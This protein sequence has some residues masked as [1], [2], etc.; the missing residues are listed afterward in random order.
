VAIDTLNALAEHLNT[1]SVEGCARF[2]EENKDHLCNLIKRAYDFATLSGDFYML[3]PARSTPPLNLP[4]EKIAFIYK[5]TKEHLIKLIQNYND[6][7]D[8]LLPL[9]NED[10]ADFYETMQDSL[11]L[12][13]RDSSH[14]FQ[15]IIELPDS[16]KPLFYE[17]VA[18]K[19]PQFD[20]IHTSMDIDIVLSPFPRSTLPSETQCRKICQALK[21]SG[22]LNAILQDEKSIEYLFSSNF[23]PK[24]L[25]IVIDVFK[26]RLIEIAQQNKDEF[27]KLTQSLRFSKRVI[28]YLAMGARF[29]ELALPPNEFNFNDLATY[30]NA[31]TTQ[32]LTRFLYSKFF[33]PLDAENKSNIF[34]SIKDQLIQKIT[35]PQD[36]LI[37]FLCLPEAPCKEICQALDAE[38][39]QTLIPNGQRLITFLNSAEEDKIKIILGKLQETKQLQKIASN[40]NFLMDLL[41]SLPLEKF[42]IAFNI[43]KEATILDTLNKKK[44][45]EL[46]AIHLVD[47]D[48]SDFIYASLKEDFPRIIN[49]LHK[50]SQI[51]LH[52]TEE[53]RTKTYEIMKKHSPQFTFIDSIDYFNRIHL[54]RVLSDLSLE[55]GRALLA[56]LDHNQRLKNLINP[57]ED[58]LEGFFR[59]LSE[60]IDRKSSSRDEK[61][62]LLINQIEE[63]K[64]AEIIH[65]DQDRNKILRALPN[66]KIIRDTLSQRIDSILLKKRLAMKK[67]TQDLSDEDK[68]RLI[69]FLGSPNAKPCH[70]A[71]LTQ[72]D[73][74]GKTLKEI[75]FD[76]AYSIKNF[77]P[78][79]Y[80][81]TNE[82][83]RLAKAFIIFSLKCY[84][85]R[86]DKAAKTASG[87]YKDFQ[88]FTTS[89]SRSRNINRALAEKL[90]AS[91][92]SGDSLETVF[93]E[94]AILQERNKIKAEHPESQGPFERKGVWSAELN[95]IFQTARQWG[96]K[97]AFSST[98]R[99]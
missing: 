11:P 19:R 59:D 53:Q 15:I 77:A 68:R 43:L 26:D 91:L 31:L 62:A 29:P 48:K 94:Q 12:L 60:H 3:S 70:Y 37:F 92:E 8:V 27:L 90:I 89:R 39:L 32:E 86:V 49:N 95:K 14:F 38:R 1:L 16:K 80:S 18:E 33:T 97:S 57:G 24:K 6:F 44:I 40:E 34:H 25:A 50:F 71:L 74:D 66:S 51:L 7:C 22:R 73:K 54:L 55:Q 67:V 99:R 64:L 93:A 28:I 4:Q 30:L 10:R 79:S 87:D 84:C 21:D 13:I 56:T 9:S 78:P 69:I 82:N 52:L 72:S 2:C 46:F 36:L 58:G 96:S 41:K 65:N 85:D 42:K 47:H 23:S 20:F 88:L 76:Y 45:F 81:I 61:I 98:L 35:T 83:D 75:L 5:V 17:K 63:A